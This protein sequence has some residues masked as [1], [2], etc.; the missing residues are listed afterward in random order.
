VGKHLWVLEVDPDVAKTLARLLEGTG[1]LVYKRMLITLFLSPSLDFM[2]THMAKA[3]KIAPFF[4]K[5]CNA[6]E[7]Q[8]KHE[9]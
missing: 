7:M 3:H 5:M 4:L 2:L 8:G 9:A 6:I 1:H